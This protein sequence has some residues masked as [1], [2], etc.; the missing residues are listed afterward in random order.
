LKIEEADIRL[1]LVG[2][3]SEETAQLRKTNANKAA[4]SLQGEKLIQ[5]LSTRKGKVEA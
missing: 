3:G 1:S 2:T 4:Q 5:I